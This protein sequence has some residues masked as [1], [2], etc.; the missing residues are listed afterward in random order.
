MEVEIYPHEWSNPLEQLLFVQIIINHYH[1]QYQYYYSSVP[2][3]QF[4]PGIL[5][6][7]RCTGLF[8]A[9]KRTNF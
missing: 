8:L 7:N 2:L 3:Y 6:L 9:K 5:F 1:Y 4:A